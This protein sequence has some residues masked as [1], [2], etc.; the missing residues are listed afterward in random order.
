MPVA[1]NVKIPSWFLAHG[2][3]LFAGAAMRGPATRHRGPDRSADL[4]LF[5]IRDPAGARSDVD[6][7]LEGT[8]PA[9]WGRQQGDSLVA[10]K[11]KMVADAGQYV[12]ANPWKSVGVSLAV[13]FVLSRL[14]FH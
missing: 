4:C 14:I 3:A 12:S 5:R 8:S 13:S 6:K 10:T 7:L 2:A 9:D 11:A 1:F